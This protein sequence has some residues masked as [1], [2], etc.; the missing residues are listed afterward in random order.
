MNHPHNTASPLRLS[1]NDLAKQFVMHLQNAAVID[2]FANLS[3]DVNSGDC[4]VL[5]GPSGMGKS[6]LIKCLYGNYQTS[7]GNIWI[8]FDDGAVDI[9]AVSPNWIYYLRRH[10]VGYVSQFLRVVPRVAAI[11]IVMEPLVSRG[12]DEGIAKDKAAHLLARL[13]IPESLWNLS[14][15]TF[16]GGEQQRINIAR[17]F[18]APY[19]VLLLDEPT[20]S[21]DAEN[22]SVVVELINEAKQQGS[23]IV[24]IFHDENVRDAIAS[25]TI[26]LS[27]Y[28]A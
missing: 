8:H 22:R 21:L 1:V 15:T 23:A 14:P 28:I 25:R 24:G 3:M 9:T 2:V 18:V 6:T 19:P 17:G 26:D 16:S 10:V 5:M 4:V 11:D 13:N 20:A 12:V 7:A 27:E